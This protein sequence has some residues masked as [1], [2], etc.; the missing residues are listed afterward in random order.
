[1]GRDLVINLKTAKSL[2]LTVRETLLARGDEV[3]PL[4]TAGAY[5]RFGRG[6]GSGM[7]DESVV[8]LLIDR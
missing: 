8:V 5:G 7:G 4:P 3:T 2:G 6:L 1:M